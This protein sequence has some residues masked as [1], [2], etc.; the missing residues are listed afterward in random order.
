MHLCNS[1]VS[2][3]ASRGAKHEK[4]CTVTLRN[5]KE[6]TSQ[7]TST[8]L[9]NVTLANVVKLMQFKIIL[10]CMYG[11]KTKNFHMFF[12]GEEVYRLSDRDVGK[13][14]GQTPLCLKNIYN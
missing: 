11:R 13:E 2:F 5:K 12:Y 10:F 4:L 14:D 3:V 1:A 9:I 6:I 7:D 8:K